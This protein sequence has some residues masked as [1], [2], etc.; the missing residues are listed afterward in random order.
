MHL[1]N[2][3]QRRLTLLTTFQLAIKT[4]KTNMT[5]VIL[6]CQ[7]I[8][9]SL[10][11]FLLLLVIFFTIFS[12]S[13]QFQIYWTNGVTS[14]TNKKCPK[15]TH[16][17]QSTHKISLKLFK[18]IWIEAFLVNLLLLLLVLTRKQH[19]G[20]NCNSSYFHIII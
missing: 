10:R 12:F 7:L 16:I 5:I 15:Y 9:I 2:P 14:N 19:A 1:K 18:T 17:I 3:N 11:V 4:T 13:W 6:T 20:I 8:S